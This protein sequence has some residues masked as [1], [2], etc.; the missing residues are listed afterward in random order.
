MSDTPFTRFG[1]DEA[2]AGQ[3]LVEALA[4][5]GD[6]ADL[7]F[8]DRRT[9]SLVLDD[10]RLRDADRAVHLGLGVRV[11]KGEAT[12]YAYTEDLSRE[13]MMRAARTAASVAS[14]GG[15][16]KGIEVRGQRA[17]DLYP[18]ER[19]AWE[20]GVLDKLAYLRR[21]D[22]AAR[23]L[24][25]QKVSRVTV[26]LSD[27]LRQILI[28]TSEGRY[29]ADRQ[30]M[31]RFNCSVVAT[32]GDKRQSGSDGGGGRVGLEYFDE[33]S[34]EDIGRR[35][36]QIAITML[37]AREAP[38]GTFPV[39]LGPGDAGVLLH[40]AVGHGLEAD[41]NRKKTSNYSDRVGERVA[42]PG[43]TIVDD[44]TLAS[45][46]GT[47]NVDDEGHAPRRNVLI[48]DG[49]LQAYMHDDLS[50]KHFG[51]GPSGN[52]RRQDYRYVPM[53]RMTNTFMLAGQDD[54]EEIV[55]SV[56]FGVYACA[57]SG[58][59]VNISNGDF[60]FSVTEGYLIEDGK[61]T[62][63]VKGV[64]LIGNGPEALTQVSMIGHDFQLSD[65]RWTCGKAGQSVPVGIGMPTLK[66]DAMTV[67]GGHVG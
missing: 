10:G 6:H 48:E 26:S 51:L 22:A 34:P 57:F 41:F 58:G 46:R 32:D 49:I 14:G 50:T 7:F 55:R 47:I 25:P 16:P 15:G 39:V 2:L 28:V 37:D 3:V 66:V 63:P 33:R 17:L 13:G 59:Q 5:G 12:G 62:A 24:D 20:A 42:A 30:P 36:A 29:V 27:T 54:P 53:P 31:I 60:V 52:G 65:G 19:G 4:R 23:A 35:A 9:T 40:E 45:S 67:G 1:L 44:G 38:A 8:E 56:D 21:A 64:N 43:V 11:L 18:V 61:I